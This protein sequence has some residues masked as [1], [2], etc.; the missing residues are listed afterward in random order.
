[1]NT[2]LITG[3]TLLAGV[4]LGYFLSLRTIKAL[5]RK[6]RDLRAGRDKPPKETMKRVVWSCV[7]NGFA[8]VWCSYILAALDRTQIAE[9]L[10]KVALAEIVVPVSVYA[11]KSV[12]ENLSKNNLWPDK[13]TASDDTSA[14]E[15]EEEPD[16]GKG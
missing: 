7:I 16:A 10:S 14:P 12:L 9:E 4:A 13:K 6:V 8:W 11:L 15:P 3:A 1:M 2:A 5:R